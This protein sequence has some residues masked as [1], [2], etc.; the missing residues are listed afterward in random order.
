MNDVDLCDRILAG[1]LYAFETFV[2]KYQ[3][4][5]FRYYFAYFHNYAIA[6]DIAQGAFVKFHFNIN[7]IKN[8]GACRSYLFTIA[9]NLCKDELKKIKRLKLV[10]PVADVNGNDET[11]DNYI[12]PENNPIDDMMIGMQEKMKLK[13]LIKELNPEQRAA[14]TLVHF[15]EMK[16]KDAGVLLGVS[17]GTIKSRVNRGLKKIAKQFRQCS[18]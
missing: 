4:V 15:E 13:Q 3:K 12:E 17:E 5:L 9:K 7:K 18:S 6:S 8:K 14:I 10:P 2:N 16:Y 11:I 1:D